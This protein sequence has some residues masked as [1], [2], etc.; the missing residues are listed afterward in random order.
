MTRIRQRLRPPTSF[1]LQIY[2]I[3][4]NDLFQGEN[5]E[6]RRKVTSLHPWLYSFDSISMIKKKGI[7]CC[8]SLSLFSAGNQGDTNVQGGLQNDITTV[9]LQKKSLKKSSSPDTI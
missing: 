6:F 2:T 8:W 7:N 1:F 9:S 5:G 3:H 4:V